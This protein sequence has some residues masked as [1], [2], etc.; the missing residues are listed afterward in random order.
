[1]AS[2]EDEDFPYDED[3]SW[4]AA[5]SSRGN[6]PALRSSSMHEL[7]AAFP[8]PPKSAPEFPLSL[9]LLRRDTP[10]NLL[11]PTPPLFH[12]A[13]SPHIYANPMFAEE[14]LGAFD[15]DQSMARLEMSMT[16]LEGFGPISDEPE[17]ACFFDDGEDSEEDFGQVR[18]RAAER[19][20][21]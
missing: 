2:D 8:V 20:S 1:M 9:F 7:A 10:T 6:T 17:P 19:N 4:E 12:G 14:R 5:S 16:K 21:H 18:Y 11:L 3:F 13:R 15:P